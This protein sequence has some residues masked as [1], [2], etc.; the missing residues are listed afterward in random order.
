M[1]DRKWAAALAE[2]SQHWGLCPWPEDLVKACV[3]EGIAK[4]AWHVFRE[5]SLEWARNPVPELDGKTIRELQRDAVFG[6]A[7]KGFLAE[8]RPLKLIIIKS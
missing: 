8:Q 1:T 4:A 2:V 5:G 3:D 6:K 7:V